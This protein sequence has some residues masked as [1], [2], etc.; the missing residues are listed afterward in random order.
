MARV[1]VIGGGF[2]GLAAALRL[3][4]L[5]HVVTLVEER[6]LG[7]VLVPVTADAFAWDTVTHTLLPGVVRDLFRKTGRPLDKELE[8]VQLDCLREHWFADGTSLVLSAGRTAQLDA[9]DS[10]AHGLGERWLAH[11]DAYA[12]DWE[13]VRRQYAEV[14]WDPDHVGRDL[15]ARLDARESLRKRLRSRLPDERPRLVAAH[16]FTADGHD[17]RDV[18]AWAGLTAYLEQRFGAWAFVGGTADLLDALV[19]RLETRKVAVVRGRATDVLVRAGRA[20]AVAT[21]AGELDADVVVC[22]VDPRRLPALAESVRRTTPAIPATTTYL[23]LAGDVRD[24]PHELVVHGDPT[25]VLRTRGRA[26]Q[27]HHAWTVQVRGRRDE[28]ALAAVVRHG[29]LVRDQ[30]VAR[31]DLSPRELVERWGGSPSGVQWQGRSTVRRRL[32]PRTPIAGVYAAGSH[33]TPGSGIPYVGLS[34]SLVAQVVGP[35]SG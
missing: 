19:R 12:D 11:V 8:L 28:D 35:A 33:A 4:K 17:P 13:V 34:A 5:G 15:T 31:L 25:L 22:A 7:G 21:T 24:L 10:L 6:E 1:V 2:G 3:A 29:L 30:V 16:P 26:P 32:G 27:G 14:P 20:V 23:G 9:F 18:P